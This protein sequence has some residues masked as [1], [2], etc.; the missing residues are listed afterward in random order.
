ML[1][2]SWKPLLLLWLS[3]KWYVSNLL[4]DKK[5][6]SYCFKKL[7]Y[8]IFSKLWN[9]NL[10]FQISYLKLWFLMGLKYLKNHFFYEQYFKKSTYLLILWV[11][12]LAYFVNQFS[13]RVLFSV[14]MCLLY[15]LKAFLQRLLVYFSQSLEKCI[16]SDFASLVSFHQIKVEACPQNRF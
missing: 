13:L 1:K 8:L 6:G 12:Y 2:K 15:Y 14:S 10:Y 5:I 7:N 9:R 16:S 4:S 11:S 3:L